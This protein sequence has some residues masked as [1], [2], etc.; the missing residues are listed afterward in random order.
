MDNIRKDLKILAKGNGKY[1][2]FNKKIVNTKK[3]VLGGRVPDIR[4]LA[5][6]LAKDLDYGDALNYLK[7][8]NKNVY[9][10][11]LLFGFIIKYAKFCDV[12]K[13][14]LTRKY[15]KYADSWALIDCF[16]S[17]NGKFDKKKWFNFAVKYLSSKN[18]FE[19]RFG[20]IFLMANFL[21]KENIDEVFATLVR[22]KHKGYYVKMGL[23]WLYSTAAVKFYKKTLDELKKNV[24]SGSIDAWTYK[25]AFQKMIESYRFTDKQKEE[26]K[27][28]KTII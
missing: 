28:L 6:I 12:Q 4:K 17:S 14:Q 20:I 24:K 15:L 9:E 10:E 8:C 18:E 13:I 25:K 11:V 3:L 22:V 7:S 16:V 21:D 1:S 23:A 2:K 19:A 26:I 5:K 27:S